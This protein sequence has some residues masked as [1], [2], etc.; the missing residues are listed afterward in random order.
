MIALEDVEIAL[1]YLEE[2]RYA[3]AKLF[4]EN[5]VRAEQEQSKKGCEK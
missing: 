3:S 5:V 4:L 1:E 2:K